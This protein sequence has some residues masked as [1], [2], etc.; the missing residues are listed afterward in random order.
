MSSQPNYIT[1]VGSRHYFGVEVFKVGQR[2]KL[3]KN[4]ENPHD[5]EAIKVEL[6]PIG[7]VGYVANST[8][9]VARGTRSAGRIY[10]L[11]NESCS[12]QVMFILKGDVIVQLENGNNISVE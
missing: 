8:H 2:V 6:E 1:V 11:F 4:Y 10:D 9:T 7:K 12:G 5:S 3:T